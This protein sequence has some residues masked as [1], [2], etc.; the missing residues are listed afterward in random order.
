MPKFRKKPVEVEAVKASV[1]IKNANE[2]NCIAQ[3]AWI[4]KYVDEQLIIFSEDCLHIHTLEGI[5]QAEFNDYIIQGVNGEIYP[6]KPD[7]F[8]KT[9]EPVENTVQ[10]PRDDIASLNMG[11]TD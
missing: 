2:S 10:D 4:R 11:I 1:L 8:E 9:Y 6:C 7:I 3:P 5:M